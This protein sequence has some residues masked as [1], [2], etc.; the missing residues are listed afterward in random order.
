MSKVSEHLYEMHK[1]HH[2]DRGEAIANHQT[3][4][5]KATAME[6]DGGPHTTLLKAEIARHQ[7][8]QAYHAEGMTECAKAI[9][10]HLNKLVPTNISVVVP[11]HP[12]LRAIPRAGQP[13]IPAK[14]DV[15]LEFAKMFAID[16]G[17]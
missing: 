7:K 1:F 14:P 4:L 12:G 16:D 11:E 17:E 5:E 6:P 15:P 3:A 13:A 9:Q 2:G 8:A 10:D